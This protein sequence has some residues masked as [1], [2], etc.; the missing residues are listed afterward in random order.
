MSTNIEI[1]WN[2][3]TQNIQHDEFIEKKIHEKV[4]KIARHLGGFP[5]DSVHLHV[6]LERSAK[7]DCFT[8]RLTLRVPS[9]ILH[10]EKTTDDLIKA[11][12]LAIDS[13]LHDLEAFKATL[14]GSRYWKRKERRDL[15]HYLKSAAFAL[16]AQAA[17]TG[18]Q[19]DEDVLRDLFQQHHRELLHHARRHLR[20]DEGAGEITQNAIDAR[21]VVDEVQKR[22][23]AK[24]SEGPKGMNWM[25]WFYH[26]IHEE[27][28]RRRSAL[29]NQQPPETQRPTAQP[30]SEQLQPPSAQAREH[31]HDPLDELVTQKDTLDLLQHDMRTWPRSEREVFELYYVEGLDPEEIEVATGYP[32]QTVQQNLESVRQ[33]LRERLHQPEVTV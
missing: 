15:S 14:T 17:G 25:V 20:H 1:P 27:L 5:K 16:Q 30:S 12:N 19:N 32:L 28:K 33:K 11:L 8:A 22:A 3:I 31:E 2:F 18:P 23:V 9:N 6:A 7:Q 26:L 13:L 21:E 24:A 10:S 29:K 4:A